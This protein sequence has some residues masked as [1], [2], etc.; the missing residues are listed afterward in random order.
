MAQGKNPRRELRTRLQ[1]AVDKGIALREIAEKA[2]ISQTVISDFRTGRRPGSDHTVQ[3]LTR[4]LDR[5]SEAEARGYEQP[6]PLPTTDVVATTDVD[7]TTDVGR[8]GRKLEDFEDYDDVEIKLDVPEDVE[9]AGP[10]KSPIMATSRSQEKR[11]EAQGVRFR[12]SDALRNKA[13]RARLEQVIRRTSTTAEAI[14][15]R[16]NVSSGSMST[17][18]RGRDMGN[19]M[20]DRLS[21]ALD[22][23]EK[24]GTTTEKA[25]TPAKLPPFRPSSE[26]YE[27]RD[28]VAA[29]VRDRIRRTVE[30][31]GCTIADLMSRLGV[32]GTFR[33]FYRDQQKVSLAMLQHYEAA[34]SALEAGEEPPPAPVTMQGR[35]RGLVKSDTA[36][37]PLA[38]SAQRTYVRHELKERLKSEFGRD[39]GA[40]GRSLGMPASKIKQ[41]I[42]GGDFSYGNARIVWDQWHP[43]IPW[44]QPTAT[45]GKQKQLSLAYPVAEADPIDVPEGA[46]RL[47]VSA[48]QADPD[49][50]AM[51][52]RWK[53]E[54]L[55]FFLTKYGPTLLG[56]FLK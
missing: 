13:I 26:D 4:V 44:N 23:V 17:F 48:A 16:A 35:P 56:G 22:E 33:A 9:A 25:E 43:D 31:E 40:L 12:R 38:R 32:R 14:G 18:R 41:A 50:A 49:A 37:L 21:D 34:L 7:T 5:L 45:R 39:I 46:R 42:D 53:A 24:E 55:T 20:V 3:E 11:Y 1:R 52:D 29:R 28:V 15:R 27:E 47:R 6:D 8:P 51:L 19:R 54:A 2:G 30:K 10:V 36:G